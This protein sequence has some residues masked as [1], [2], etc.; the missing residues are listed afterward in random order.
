MQ[1]SLI[2][3]NTGVTATHT[4]VKSG[5]DA[6]ISCVITGITSQV[7]VEW[8]GPSGIIR[9]DANYTPHPGTYE[10]TDNTQTATL[11]VKGDAVTDDRIFTC[12]VKSGTFSESP[13]ANT[14]V[15]LN[16]YGR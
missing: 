5:T 12:R 9:S 10:T 16:V 4:E 2:S 15:Q 14:E 7:T 8:L 3:Y 11:E 13:S 6:T 1:F